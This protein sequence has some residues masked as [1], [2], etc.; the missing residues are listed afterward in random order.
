[1]S[2]NPSI[3]SFKLQSRF[4]DPGRHHDALRRWPDHLPGL[5]SAVQN[6]LIYDVAAEPFYGVNLSH[7]RQ[8]DIHLRYAA[9]ILD[10]ALQINP[11]PFN[12]ERVAHSRVAARCNN[13]GLILSSALRQR[14]VPARSRSGFATYFKSGRYEDHWV[15]EYFDRAEGRWHYA[16]PQFDE[17]WCRMLGIQHDPCDVPRDR[18][19]TAAEVWR[20]CGTGLIDP[21]TVGV[22]HVGLYGLFMVAGSLVRD[23]AAL[24]HVELLPWDVWGAQPRP[25]SVMAQSQLHYFDRLAELLLSPDENADALRARY[26]QDPGL[27]VAGA[28]FNALLSVQ[29]PIDPPTTPLEQGDEY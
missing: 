4:T 14:G 25:G 5:M 20:G 27:R 16:D 12:E 1:M 17:T 21:S 29:Q 3:E 6:L 22:H 10:R 13:F 8:V 2:H 11:V 24:N 26:E 9:Q 18:F 23:I 28:A 7:E 19:L 15:I